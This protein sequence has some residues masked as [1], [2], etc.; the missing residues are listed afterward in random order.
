MATENKYPNPPLNRVLIVDDSNLQ[1]QLLG[2]VC[3]E[4]GYNTV[5]AENGK[6][7]LL[8]LEK[9]EF[10][11]IITD[12]EM[13]EMDGVQF[14][15][16]IAE[17]GIKSKI[18]LVSGVSDGLLNSAEELARL[19]GLAISGKLK[20]P[21]IPE[22]CLSLIGRVT[23]FKGEEAEKKPAASGFTQVLP[24][25]IEVGIRYGALVPYYQ[26]KVDTK[27]GI[28]TGLECLARWRDHNG[29]LLGPGSFVPAAEKEG[30]ISL[31]TREMIRLSFKDLAAWKKKGKE[32]AVSIN[33]SADD[34]R[35]PVFPDLVEE[36][37]DEH[38]ISPT[39]VT[40]EIT[41]TK[42]M[43]QVADCL[44]SMSRLQLKGFGLSIDDF[45]TGYSSLKQLQYSP[46]TELKIDR[47]FVSKAVDHAQSRT[48][49]ESSIQLAAN[50]GLHC[51][52]EG[53]ETVQQKELLESLG[54]YNHQGF[55][56]AR[57]MPASRVISWINQWNKEQPRKGVA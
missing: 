47:S 51:V 34:L 32:I 12:L 7:G 19:D 56:Y 48:V 55:L 17:R 30:L 6:E 10:D 26:P 28:V 44:G 9:D 52:A 33:A 18:I 15:R 40:I 21:Y 50:L 38:G 36:M 24:E 42:V 25:E 39:E 2:V 8:L 31:L 49:L 54:C 43:E 37:A 13:P 23:G 4:A 45:G 14:L 11:L 41:E 22:V 20:K 16:K 27:R 5:L 53:I 35:N 57:P 46:F 3:V 1:R 29:Q